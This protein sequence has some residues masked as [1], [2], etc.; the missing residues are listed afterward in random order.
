MTPAPRRNAIALSIPLLLIGALRLVDAPAV[1]AQEP[2]PGDRPEALNVFLDC[3]TFFCDFD[4]FRREITFVNWMRNREDADV[5]VLVTAQRTG[6]GGWEFT[7]AFIG[8]RAFQQRVDTLQYTS[9]NTDTE[10]EVRDGLTHTLKLGLVRFAAQTAVAPRIQIRYEAPGA[11][12]QIRQARPEDD[13]WNFW[14]FQVRLNGSLEGEARQNER[15]IRGN[16][17]ASRVTEHLKIDIGF[18]GRASREEFELDETTT[19]VNTSEN[20]SLDLLV[21][22]SLGPHWS[23][24]FG[25]DLSRSTFSNRDLGLSGGPALEFNIFP[26]EESTRQQISFTY[27]VEG[28]Y[29]NYEQITVEDELAETLPRHSLSIRASVNQPWGQVFGSVRGTQYLHDVE[30]HRIDTF[31]GFDI[32]LF[33]GFSVNVFGNVARIKDQFFL[34][35]AGQT[36]EEILRQRRQ[37]ETNFSFDISVGFSFRFGSKFANVVNPRMGGGSGMFFFF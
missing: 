21:V 22:W 7:L 8:R 12:E 29:F 5:H 31:G 10:A 17:S 11:E 28:A 30:V 13:P 37:R 2:G 19:F 3:Q 32:R 27:R 6:G 25:T 35:A 36:E 26:Y 15:G 20:G 14:T 34:P 23:A 24:G 4:H 9:L 16:V 33:R 18:F 1:A